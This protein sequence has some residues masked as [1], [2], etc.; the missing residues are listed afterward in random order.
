MWGSLDAVDAEGRQTLFICR[1][2]YEQSLDSRESS[3][4]SSLIENVQR[5][6]KNLYNSDLVVRSGA[7][8]EHEVGIYEKFLE[9]PYCDAFRFA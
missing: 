5:K 4:V 1:P 2:G 7:T 9:L 6:A 8:L 3:K